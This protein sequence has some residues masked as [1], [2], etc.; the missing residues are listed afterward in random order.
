MEYVLFCSFMFYITCNEYPFSNSQ[1]RS[2]KPNNGAK[3]QVP[4]LWDPLFPHRPRDT[5]VRLSCFPPG[6]PGGVSVQV[7]WHHF[8]VSAQ[9]TCTC[10]RFRFRFVTSAGQKGQSED[11]VLPNLVA[12]LRTARFLFG[13]SHAKWPFRLHRG[14]AIRFPPLQRG[15]PRDRHPM[16]WGGA[17]W[18]FHQATAVARPWERSFYWIFLMPDISRFCLRFLDWKKCI[19]CS[20]TTS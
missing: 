7:Q 5:T 19:V 20:E 13:I 18:R 10:P 6:R 15:R 11:A 3:S 9:G 16:G 12:T 8:P 17:K 2:L 1:K 4:K 14:R